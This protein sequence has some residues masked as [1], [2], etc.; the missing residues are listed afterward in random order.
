MQRGSPVSD[1]EKKKERIE[2]MKKDLSLQAGRLIKNLGISIE[3]DSDES[4]QKVLFEETP[5]EKKI[6][7]WKNE[8]SLQAERLIQHNGQSTEN[9]FDDRKFKSESVRQDLGIIFREKFI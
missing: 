3:N 9:N 2:F 5:Q 1:N 4:V 6:E 7:S 8:M